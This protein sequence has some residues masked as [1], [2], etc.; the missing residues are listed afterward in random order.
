MQKSLF[1]IDLEAKSERM[2]NL[3]SHQ[4]KQSELHKNQVNSVITEYKETLRHLIKPSNKKSNAVRAA[5][6]YFQNHPFDKI[7]ARPQAIS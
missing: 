5:A 3:L 1:Q 2:K 7:K 4:T 6:E